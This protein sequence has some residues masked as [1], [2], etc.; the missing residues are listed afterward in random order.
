MKIF[1]PLEVF[2]PSQAGGPANTVFWI[3]KNLAKKGLNPIIIATDKGLQKDFP[4]NQWMDIDGLKV[5][6]VKTRFSNFPIRQTLIALRHLHQADIVHLS[7]IFFPTAF[8]T[9]FAARLWRKK[10][11]WSTRGELDPQALVH[12]R[13]RKKPILWL[14]KK[15]IGKYPFFHSTCDEEK[16]Y[17]KKTFGEDAQVIRIPNYLE[18]PQKVRRSPAKYLLYIGRIHPKKAID[19]LIEAVSC[20]EVFR[21]SEYVLKIAGK[22]KVKFENELRKLVNK[23]NLQN[24]VIFLGQVEGEAKQKLLADAFFTIMPSHTENF[25][26]VVLES[27]AQGTPVIASRGTPWKCLEDEKIGFWV[28]NTPESLRQKIDEILQMTSAEY[29][30]MRKRSRTFVIREFDIERNIDKWLELY[31]LLK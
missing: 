29:D 16:E 26:I 13:F 27:L 7:S 23:K 8:L 15:I 4:V 17:I 10:I 14:I 21:Q 1:F 28:E 11:V 12:S 22:G 9:G 3:T 30:Q 20:S 24:K 18:I 31:N 19:N 2:F 25:G 6:Y 5:I